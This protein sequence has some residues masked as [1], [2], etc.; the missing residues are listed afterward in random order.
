MLEN[1]GEGKKNL[2]WP[3]EFFSQGGNACYVTHY[4][5]PGASEK[6]FICTIL[7]HTS[8]PCRQDALQRYI[9]FITPLQWNNPYRLLFK[10]ERW[11]SKIFILYFWVVFVEVV[12]PTCLSCLDWQCSVRP[13]K[14]LAAETSLKMLFCRL[15]VLHLPSEHIMTYNQLASRLNPCFWCFSSNLHLKEQFNWNNVV[16]FYLYQP[17]QVTRTSFAGWCAIQD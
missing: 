4:K 17:I 12:I 3:P 5:N 1:G 16:E 14:H 2:L 10:A 13:F 9:D 8:S 7:S 6:V 15:V 11:T